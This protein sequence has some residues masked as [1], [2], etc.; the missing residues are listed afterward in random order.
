MGSGSLWN[1]IILICP[2]WHININKRCLK[3][4]MLWKAFTYWFN[5][6]IRK[7]CNLLLNLTD[8]SK[9]ELKTMPREINLWITDIKKPADFKPGMEKVVLKNHLFL[10]NWVNPP[11]QNVYK[12]NL[13]NI[14]NHL[15]IFRQPG[16]CK[17]LS[18]LN[19]RN[20]AQRKPHAVLLTTL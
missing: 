8:K 4:E 14:A 13:N 16:H 10:I 5:K 1:R 7:A 12:A 18:I 9:K 19:L 6:I 15:G 17:N 11:M 2:I 3:R 20:H